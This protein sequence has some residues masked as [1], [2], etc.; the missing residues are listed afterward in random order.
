MHDK[1]LAA[2]LLGGDAGK[3]GKP[4][5]GMN[6]IELAGLLH[7]NG[8][9]HLGITGHLLKQVGAV[10]AGE[11]ELLP[12]AHR[13]LTELL[14]LHLLDGLEILFRV[15]IRDY[16]GVHIDELHLVKEL[17][18]AAADIADRDIAGADYPGAALV[19]VTG[20][21]RHHEKHLDPIVGQALDYPFAGRPETA[22]DMG[23]ELPTE[24]QY[25]HLLFSLY[26]SNMF[27]IESRAAVLSAE[28]MAPCGS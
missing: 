21:G 16:A 13:G 9:G 1:R 22:G 12:E 2:D 3:V 26:L 24:H 25:C 8:R 5:V 6:D 27:S 19:L 28:D 23:R 17:V 7:R 10:L 14:L 4:V 20:C 11:L 18:D 15:H